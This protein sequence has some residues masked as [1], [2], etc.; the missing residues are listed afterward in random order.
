MSPYVP[1]IQPNR[2]DI[3]QYTDLSRLPKSNP[4]LAPKTLDPCLNYRFCSTERLDRISNM[5]F[6][7]TTRNRQWSRYADKLYGACSTMEDFQQYSRLDP[8]GDNFSLSSFVDDDWSRMMGL[9]AEVID[10]DDEEDGYGMTIPQSDDSS[11]RVDDN[12][13][14]SY[15][16]SVWSSGSDLNITAQSSLS[17][18]SFISASPMSSRSSSSP[19]S[20]FSSPL[21]SPDSSYLPWDSLPQHL[22][23][24]MSISEHEIS[25]N[26][27]SLGKATLGL[28]ISSRVG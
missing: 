24:S 26:F 16:S 17:G 22:L 13:S 8:F 9:I 6:G 18:S 11:S 28:R 21:H 20:T 12:P 25:Q 7:K 10:E 15:N 4:K 5:K 2:G 19:I 14:I 1:G 27:N 3:T 23:N